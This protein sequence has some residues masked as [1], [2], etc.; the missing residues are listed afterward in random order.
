MTDT[1]PVAG[2]SGLDIEAAT[3]Y[4]VAHAAAHSTRRCAHAVRLAL[5]AGGVSFADF[6]EDAKAYGPYLLAKG[7]IAVSS[8]R[9]TP[10]KGDVAV[11]QS[12]TGGSSAGH[13]TM[14]SGT[15]WYSDFV[16]SDMWSGPG[17]RTNQPDYVIY[18]P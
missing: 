12:Y 5:L 6:P 17:Y 9:Y 2:N 18:R 10:G 7:F 1:L 15:A 11:I 8:A 14:Y 13:I 3:T 4:L 16:Q